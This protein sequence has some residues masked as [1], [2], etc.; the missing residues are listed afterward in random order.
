MP[1]TPRFVLVTG[2]S[3]G[4]GRDMA[5]HLATHGFEVL[6]G[7]RSANDGDRLAAEAPAGIHPVTLDVTDP[8]SIRAATREV[9]R[10][11][12]DAGLAGLVNNAGIAAFGPLEQ[13]PMA[14]FEQIFRVNVIGVQAL[15]QALLPALRR[16]CGRIVNISSGNGK[17]VMPF[18]GAYCASKFALEAM[19]DALRMELAPWG[20]HVVVVE[21]GAMGTDI[22]LRAVDD[23]AAER[24]DLTGEERDLYADVFAVVSGAIRGMEAGVGPA[25]DISVAVRHALTD[26]EPKTRYAVGPF[27]DQL[28]ALVAM[29]DRE[30]DQFAMGILGLTGPVGG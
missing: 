6:A 21:P 19:S 24:E 14:K 13:Q 1:A 18:T 30:R 25:S 20:M 5:L 27:M 28:D 4:L 11:T 10:I 26:P 15:T 2:A 3:R 12:G 16:A 17:L 8:E 7:V 29:P 22:R 23:W 9:E